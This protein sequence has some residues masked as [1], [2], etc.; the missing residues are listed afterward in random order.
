MSNEKSIKK[1]LAVILAICMLFQLMLPMSAAEDISGHWAAESI[2]LLLSKD[3]ISG[4][5]NGNINPD[6]SITRAEFAKIV[7]RLFEY[8]EKGSDNFPDVKS[9]RWYYD[10]FSIAKKA[11]YIIGDEKGNANPETNISR[12]EVAVILS[13]TLNL[14]S[15]K[16]N[17]TFKDNASIPDWSLSSIIAM[18]ENELVNGYP[19]GTYRSENNLSRAEGFKIIANIINSGL[20]EEEEPTPSPTPKYTVTFNLNYQGSTGAP[21]SQTVSKDDLAAKPTDPAREG[22]IFDGWYTEATCENEFSFSTKIT[23]NITLYAKWTEEGD[24]TNPIITVMTEFPSGT[25]SENAVDITYSATP[26]P[27]ASIVEVYYSINDGAEEYIYL[28]GDENVTAKG[29]LGTGRVLLV[30]GEN[31]IVFTAKDSEGRTG[32][33]TVA[34]K[35]VYEFGTTPEY[36]DEDT[37]PLSSDPSKSFVKNRLIAIAK[38]GTAFTQVQEVVSGYEGTIIG[39]VNVIDMYYLQFS[40]CTEGDL[41]FLCEQLMNSTPAIF[42]SVSLDIVTNNGLEATPTNDPWW[43]TNSQ[44]GLDAIDVPGAWENYGGFFRN[45]KAGVVDNGFRNTH[46]DLQVPAAN[47]TNVGDIPSAN[48]TTSHGTHT[49]GTVAAIH[50]NS[51]GLSGVINLRRNS[52]YG[53]DAFNTTGVNYTDSAVLA[54][55]SWMVTNG[56]KVIN[57]SLG[58]SARNEDEIQELLYTRAIQRLLDHGYDFVIS[59]SAGNATISAT[60]TGAFRSVVDTDL[61]QRIIVVGAVDINGDIAN[62]SNYG[63]RVDVMAPGVRIYSTVAANNSAYSDTTSSGSPWS[64]TSMA[65][66]HIAGVA[67][68]VWAANPGLSGAQ[69]KEIIV[70][71]ANNFGFEVVDSRTT[72]PAAQRITYRQVNA[73]AAVEMAIGITPTLTTGRLA[74]QVVAATTD[75]S[76][77]APISNAQIV[78]YSGINNPAITSTVSDTSGQYVIN[79]IS[80]GRYYLEVAAEG[81]ITERFFIQIE[82]GVTTHI[83]RLSAIPSST[84]DGI[85]SGNI[86]NAYTGARVYSEVTLDFRRGIDYDPDSPGEILESITTS[87]GSYS[88]TLPAGNYTITAHGEGFIT[89]TSYV[90]AYGGVTVTSQNVVISPVFSG[91]DSSVRIVLT[92]GSTPSDLDSHLV[93][94]KPDGD[95][96]HVFYASMS[97]HYNLDGTPTLYANL[98]VDDVS[99]YGPETV[100]INTLTDGTYDYYIHDFTNRSSTTS[101]YLRNSQAVIRIYNSDNELLR[102]FNVPTGGGASTIW[103]VFK[104]S[105]QDGVY[106]IIPVNTMHNEPTSPG[107]IGM[108]SA[109]GETFGLFSVPRANSPITLTPKEIEAKARARAESEYFMAS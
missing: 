8:T 12:G 18:Q 2:N 82:A 7:N 74:G 43:G 45:I 57:F 88:V 10:E 32:H 64:G 59:Q 101:D 66:P 26:G 53:Y 33:F 17:S 52:V 86:I 5:E 48:D 105:V 4:D 21:A 11:G 55:L 25:T 56:A 78:L 94:P 70:D 81:Y 39:Q 6:N 75:G 103:H 27:D 23:A 14:T 100:T 79:N 80:T 65:A 71:S 96:F 108:G 68:M 84:Q 73:R 16:E 77:G 9:G 42:D 46:E 31:T 97:Y 36:S 40:G 91:G 99:S 22:Y 47:V 87:S 63:E 34:N 93:G 72:V 20:L 38:Y 28:A 51:V 44:W 102:T 76:S 106:T 85:I 54:G 13:R 89:T 95:N 62:F 67:A 35:P 83:H 92:W 1:V 60:K 29:E 49:L 104:F 19:D 15:S 30:P 69:V 3:I 37:Q 58:E 109:S 24:D 41:L 90:Y 50:N 98:D 61:T 107:N